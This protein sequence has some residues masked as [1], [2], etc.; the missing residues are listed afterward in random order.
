MDNITDRTKIAELIKANPQSIAAI[1]SLAKPLEKLRNPILRKIMA[2]RVTIAEAAKMGGVT[3]DDFRRVLTPLGFVFEKADSDETEAPVLPKPD[4]LQQAVVDEIDFYDVRP[5]IDNGAD[6]LKAILQ[7]FKEV[8]PGSILCI[9]NSFVPTPL[10]HLLK[11]EKAED[12]FVETISEK[13]HHT[14]FLKK[15]KPPVHSSQTAHEKLMMDDER[16]FGAVHTRFFPDK[17]REID[18]RA[19]EMPGP[20]QAILAELEKLPESYALYVHHKRVPLYLLEE[21]ADKS[22]E[23]HIYNIS[24]GDVKMLIF[25]G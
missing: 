13:E 2:S 11:Q 25:R 6:P 23:I 19:L 22:Y 9:I 14:Y 8:R 12:S 24:E 4:W 10:I 18:V 1:T 5:I 15:G 17:M 3:V 20:M 7:R 16:T 21:L